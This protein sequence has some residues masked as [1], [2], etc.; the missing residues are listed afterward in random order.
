MQEKRDL[1]AKDVV[2]CSTVLANPTLL[3]DILGTSFDIKSVI[4]EINKL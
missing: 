2:L 4:E 3:T 1:V